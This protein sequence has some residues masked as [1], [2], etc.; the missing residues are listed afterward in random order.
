MATI[1]RDGKHNC[2]DGFFVIVQ[3]IIII[4]VKTSLKCAGRVPIRCVVCRRM[5]INKHLIMLCADM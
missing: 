4:D 3:C 1:F 2:E 5:S